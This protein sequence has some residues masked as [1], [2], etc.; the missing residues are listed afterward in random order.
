MKEILSKS[1]GDLIIAIE[2]VG[3]TSVQGLA[4]KPI[5]DVDIVIENYDVFPHVIQGLENIGYFPQEEWSFEGREAFGRNDIYTPWDGN[6][7]YWMEHYLYV[8]NK[9][10]VELAKHLAFRDY[11]S[12]NPQV[13]MEYEN[14]KR[15]LANTVKDRTFYT[16]SK[17]EFISNILEKVID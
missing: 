2:H 5:L 13:V 12:S 3:S 15:K 17:T 14:L 7:T 6:S 16:L 4:A 8:F 11:L 10:S 9:D 1:L